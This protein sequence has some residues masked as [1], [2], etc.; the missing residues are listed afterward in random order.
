MMKMMIDEYENEKKEYNEWSRSEQERVKQ[1]YKTYEE[2]KYHTDHPDYP[3]S[4][5]NITIPTSDISN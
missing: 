5:Y 1:E 4:I 2:K 3:K